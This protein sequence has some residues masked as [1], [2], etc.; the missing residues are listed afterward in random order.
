LIGGF[1]DLLMFPYT[2][3]GPTE[4]DKSP[5]GVS[6]ACDICFDLVTPPFGIVL[7]PSA[8]DWTSM[9][10]TAVNKNSHARHREGDVDGTPR[11]LQQALVQ[12]ETQSALVKLRSDHSFTRVVTSRR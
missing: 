1:A 12:S 11:C 4:F 9:P 6:I 2:N 7:W 5:I 10:E 3:D 8:V